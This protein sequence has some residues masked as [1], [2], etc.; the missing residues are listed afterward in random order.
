M[1]YTGQKNAW[2]SGELYKEWIKI[3]FLPSV[4]EFQG[5]R[6]NSNQK[7]LLLVDNTRCHLSKEEKEFIDDMIIVQNLPSNVAALIEPMD[8]GVIEKIKHLYRKS[9]LRDMLLDENTESLIEF[10]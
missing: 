4:R 3:V 2:M 8:Q 10:L 1:T 9:L 5:T 7:V 6:G